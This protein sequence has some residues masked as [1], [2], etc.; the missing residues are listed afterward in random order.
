M[1]VTNP[2][3][4]AFRGIWT[5]LETDTALI[6]SSGLVPSNNCVKM[7][8][9]EDEDGASYKRG[10]QRS[11]YQ[12]ADFPELRVVKTGGF[13]HEYFDSNSHRVQA[14]FRIDTRT[15]DQQT[16]KICLVQWQTII[17]M[18]KWRAVLSALTL[19]A[20]GF[21]SATYIFDCGMMDFKENLEP[22]P[23]IKG[24]HQAWNGYIDMVVSQ[25]AIIAA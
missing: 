16:D 12:D 5:I 6:G 8:F 21:S 22:G 4:L 24:W 11:N 1:A 3:L 20:T 18:S 10:P 7:F 2:F 14:H 23:L 17:A 19:P 25:S 13:T 15:G 9:Q